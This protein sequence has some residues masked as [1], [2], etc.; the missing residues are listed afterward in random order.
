M[1]GSLFDTRVRTGITTMCISSMS[2]WENLAK[3]IDL[4]IHAYTRTYV[5]TY[6]CTHVRMGYMCVHTP[7]YKL[8]CI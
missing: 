3:S 5:H 7:E 8:L 6:G 2:F 4:S 1:L